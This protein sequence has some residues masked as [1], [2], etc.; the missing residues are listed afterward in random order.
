MV[1][2]LNVI[3][4]PTVWCFNLM[5]YLYRQYGV[6]IECYTYTDSM[7]FQL[8]VI[9]VPTV[10]CFNW[11][12]YLYRQYGVSIECYTSSDSMVFYRFSF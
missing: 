11:M 12:L 10:W 8:N 2:Q 5:L 3:P 6:S 4:V 1:F 7:V 9:P